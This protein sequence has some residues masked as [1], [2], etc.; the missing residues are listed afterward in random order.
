MYKSYPGGTD[1]EGMKVS[2]KVA[3][4]WHWERPRKAINEGT[5]SITVDSLGLK[6]S[7]KGFE[8]WHHE[9][10]LSEAIGEAYLQQKTSVY[11]EMPVP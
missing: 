2:W 4:A 9:E 8:A 10:S 5:A 7:C 1:F 11:W 6:G 3:Q